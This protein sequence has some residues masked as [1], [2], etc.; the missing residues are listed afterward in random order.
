M[1]MEKIETWTL[2]TRLWISRYN[3]GM[4]QAELA[5]RVGVAR[6]TISRIECG[7][8]LP[9]ALLALRIAEVLD[10]PM[11]RLFWIERKIERRQLSLS[12][13]TRRPVNGRRHKTVRYRRF[14]STQ[15]DLGQ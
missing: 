11:D 2:R 3:T 12:R 10:T 8:L 7:S 4:K 6:E 13:I 15:V 14:I 5:R 9:S 1:D